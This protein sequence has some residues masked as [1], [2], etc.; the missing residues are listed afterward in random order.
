MRE[1]GSRKRKGLLHSFYMWCPVAT[2]APASLLKIPYE[3]N[4]DS[5]R[6]E[7]K[8]PSVHAEGG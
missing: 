1:D 8:A 4:V 2:E 3:R 7:A 6:Y 5:V